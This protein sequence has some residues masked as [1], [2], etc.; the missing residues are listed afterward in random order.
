VLESI[1]FLTDHI[2]LDIDVVWEKVAR[3]VCYCYVVKYNQVNRYT[4]S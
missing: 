1:N 2:P 3:H 4:Y